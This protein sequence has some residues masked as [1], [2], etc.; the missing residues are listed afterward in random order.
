MT[1]LVVVSLSGDCLHSIWNE[2][3][4]EERFFSEMLND[5]DII[6][7]FDFR[8]MHVSFNTNKDC[9]QA[10]LLIEKLDWENHSDYRFTITK[11]L[12]EDEEEQFYDSRYSQQ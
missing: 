11:I 5:E 4:C 1:C 9:Q 7:D 6:A 12:N 2:Y 8:I 10:A 3:G